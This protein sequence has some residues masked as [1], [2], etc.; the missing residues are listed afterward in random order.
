MDAD[1][2]RIQSCRVTVGHSDLEASGALKDPSGT[3][4]A[5]FRSTLDLAE[6]GRLLR[7]AAQP[8]GTIQAGGN[9]AIVGSDYRV[10]GHVVGRGL[11]F[12]EGGTRL[13][14]VEFATSVMADPRRIALGGLRLS[15]MGGEFGG[16][17]EIEN[18]E[19]FRV[20]GTLSHFGIE[21]ISRTLMHRRVGY[22]GAI[23]GPLAASG[24]F[25]KPSALTAHTNLAIAPGSSANGEVPV[26]GRLNVNYS[27]AAD[28]VVL[29]P[30]YL[31][32]PHTRVDVAGSLGKQIQVRLVSHDLA[33][34]LSPVTTVPVAFTGNG[35]AVV[36]A[37]VIGSLSDARIAAQVG[38]TSFAVD[39]RPFTS[40]ATTVDASPSGAQVTNASITRGTLSA[41]FSGSVG[42]RDWSPEPYEPLKVDATIRNADARDMLAL[43]SQSSMPL[44]GD[45]AADVHVN[46]TIGSPQGN[47]A[48]FSAA[49]A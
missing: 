25:K 10:S 15:A 36:N 32:L 47:E 22:A 9:A 38:M 16:S 23:S 8:E 19:Q 12:H 11:G 43:A 24:N 27:A 37:T 40:L 14:G 18:L 41:Q 28:S 30:S 6:L 33:D 44:S 34:D 31:A 42:L 2:I 13:S 20:Q 1:H 29:D 17:A 49:R 4:S 5:Q 21:P 45:M 3:E 48:A 46:G 26:S 35:S 39:G 7:V